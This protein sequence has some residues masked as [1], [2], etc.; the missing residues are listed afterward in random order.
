MARTLANR[1]LPPEHYARPRA[2]AAAMRCAPFRR[3]PVVRA[4]LRT[5][6][7]AL[8]RGLRRRPA[9]RRRLDRAQGPGVDRSTTQENRRT[10]LLRYGGH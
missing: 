3:D 4:S 9:G 5:A 8:A 2:R 1:T 10:G 7:R 6:H